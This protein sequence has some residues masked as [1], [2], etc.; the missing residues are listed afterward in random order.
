MCQYSSVDGFANDWHL[1]HLGS[2][3]V[4]GAA[5]IMQEATAI[6]PEG[7]ITAADLGIWKDEHVEKLRQI[8]GFIHGQHALAGIQLAHA[9][10]KASTAI[11]WEGGN[12]IHPDHPGGWQIFAPS[13]IPFHPAAPEIPTPAAL[14]DAGI[15]KVKDDFVSATRRARLIGYDVVEIHAAH[16][17]LLHQFY[18]PLSNERTDQY[19]GSFE[20]RIRLLL[21]ITELVR[22][23]WGSEKPVFVRISATEWTAGGWDI[24]D[25]KK[26]AALLKEKGV[27]LIDTSS[28]GNIA[29][30]RIPLTPGYQ[31]PFAAAIKKA[32]IIPTGA[33]GLI[34]TPQ[35]A[36]DILAAGEADLIF[37]ARESLRDPNFG[38]SAAHTLKTHTPWPK[39][40]ERARRP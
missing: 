35:Q 5:L 10:R 1:V 18:S 32:D 16:G 31:V 26:L 29:K 21:E 13:P 8:V 27:D 33:V 4:G 40:Y 28:G 12:P 19:G 39:Q 36:E 24:E 37:I 14:D 6:S 7:R 15:Q 2:R 38:L 3:A 9:G 20:N 22:K 17:Y 25:S 23:E 11:P 30:A 34:T